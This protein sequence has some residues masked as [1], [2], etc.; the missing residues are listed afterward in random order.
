MAR[1]FE[2]RIYVMELFLTLMREMNLRFFKLRKFY[3]SSTYEMP[4]SP[5]KGKNLYHK[6]VY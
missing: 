3:G 5:R 6:R 1:Y 2:N 4:R